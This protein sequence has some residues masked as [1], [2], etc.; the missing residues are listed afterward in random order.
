M[1]RSSIESTLL[2]TDASLTKDIVTYCGLGAASTGHFSALLP[3]FC[4]S[5]CLSSFP[6]SFSR[7]FTGCSE[8]WRRLH[9]SGSQCSLHPRCQDEGGAKPLIRPEPSRL[10]GARAVP[11]RYGPR[12][13]ASFSEKRVHFRLVAHLQLARLALDGPGECSHLGA[14]LQP[15]R[16]VLSWAIRRLSRPLSGIPIP[17]LFWSNIGTY[18]AV[19][20]P[21]RT[22]HISSCVSR[23]C[24]L[25]NLSRRI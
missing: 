2:R 11:G 21:V 4:L 22:L 24:V 12:F 23:R 10:A 25:V 5:S 7:F 13:R 14:P 8:A 18:K 15:P 19:R 1:P 9:E 16:A 17:P 3:F 20:P 6:P